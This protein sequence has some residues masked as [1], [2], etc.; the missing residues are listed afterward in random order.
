MSS[1]QHVLV[2]N[3]R[4]FPGFFKDLDIFLA[5]KTSELAPLWKLEIYQLQLKVAF[6]T[7]FQILVSWIKC[8][9]HIYLIKWRYYF[10]ISLLWVLTSQT[11]LNT[12]YRTVEICSHAFF[13]ISQNIGSTT[14]VYQCYYENIEKNFYFKRYIGE[15]WCKLSKLSRK[16]RF[17]VETVNFQFL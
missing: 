9:T 2:W 15:F 3:I 7:R 16:C 12:F 10:S 8:F 4:G 13:E 1:L 11:L 14:V 17:Q 5:K 6:S